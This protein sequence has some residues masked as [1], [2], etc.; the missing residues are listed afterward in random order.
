M[1]WNR[2]LCLEGAGMALNTLKECERNKV[3]VAFPNYQHAKKKG[4]DSRNFYLSV[5]D[6]SAPVY[7][8][9]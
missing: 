8:S 6:A 1:G 7:S 9:V 2:S 4:K 3:G 5:C